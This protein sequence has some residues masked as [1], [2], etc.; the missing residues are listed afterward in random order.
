VKTVETVF[1]KD[2]DKDEKAAGDADSEAKYIDNRKN[3][4]L[5]Q[6]APRNDKEALEHKCL[7]VTG[8]CSQ[9][10]SSISSIY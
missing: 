10:S 9:E 4:I 6:V 3:C 1:V 5:L 8:P 7:L 2:K